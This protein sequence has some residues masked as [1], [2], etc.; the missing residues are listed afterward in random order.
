MHDEARPATVPG[1]L[2]ARTDSVRRVGPFATRGQ[3]T[4]SLDWLLRATEL[5]L[6]SVSVP[7]TV[8]WRRLHA[9]NYGVR[10]PEGRF[11]YAHVLKASLDRRRARGL[12]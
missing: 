7:H 6:R 10:D 1:T 9:T 11:E 12:P 3:A 2:L 5:G 4:E 8:L